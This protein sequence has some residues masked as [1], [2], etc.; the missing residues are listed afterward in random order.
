MLDNIEIH[1]QVWKNL[2]PHLIGGDV[3][4]A[5]DDFIQVLIENG[6]DATDI[7]EYAVDE[8]LKLALRGYVELDEEEFDNDIDE[9]G[10]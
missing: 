3:E 9:Y 1:L 4:S 7:A 2:K 10:E 5:A 6:A 8:E